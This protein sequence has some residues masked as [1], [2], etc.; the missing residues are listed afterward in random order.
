MKLTKAVG[1]RIENLLKEKNITQYRLCK[2][3]GI[4]RSTLSLIVKGS[5]ETVKLDTIYQVVAT[6]GITLSEF[7]DDELFYNIQDW[8]KIR[9]KKYKVGILPTLFIFCFVKF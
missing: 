5:Y 3:G 7:F 6:L 9:C 2:E 4:P 8:L 1:I